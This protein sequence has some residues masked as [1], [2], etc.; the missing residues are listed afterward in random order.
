[1]AACGMIPFTIALPSVHVLLFVQHM[2]TRLRP[3]KAL[4]GSDTLTLEACCS[5]FSP[6]SSQ[7]ERD[8]QLQERLPNLPLLRTRIAP[9]TIK[10]AERGLYATRDIAVGELVTLYP[11]DA[12]A[13]WSSEEGARRDGSKA[14]VSFS[15]TAAPASEWAS[16]FRALRPGFI[17]RAWEYGVRISE[18]RAIIGDPANTSDSAYLGHMANDA[19]M[20]VRPGTA[21]QAYTIKS[22]A[23]ANVMLDSLTM[24][25]C[26]HAMVATR[27]I[28][29]GA[30]IFLSYGKSYWLSRLPVKLKT[31]TFPDSSTYYGEISDGQ[32]QGAG[33]FNDAVGNRYIGDFAAGMFDG[34]G[35][36]FY[37]DGVA[38]AG[39]FV[40][41]VNVGVSVG[42]NADRSEGYRLIAIKGGGAQRHLVSIE[43]AT[44]L[45]ESLGVPVPSPWPQ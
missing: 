8:A 28:A 34:V 25:G 16:G 38:E 13:I 41:G 10:G 7:E 1:M 9:S 15:V 31:Y 35:T 33:E 19:A 2:N 45:A 23:A 40:A 44:E 43:A 24:K 36:Y 11:G 3:V 29:N 42:W 6:A 30:E 21:A 32:I 26:H 20:C 14:S 5:L 39:R 27:D 22:E 17:D 37:A 4:A 18:V 12:L